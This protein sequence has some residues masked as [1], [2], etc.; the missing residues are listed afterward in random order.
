[1]KDKINRALL[2]ALITGFLGNIVL[3]CIAVT[4]HENRIK[5]LEQY[6]TFQ[7]GAATECQCIK[8]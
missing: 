7:A 6:L 2:A 4:H 8:K 1:M 5:V 3:I